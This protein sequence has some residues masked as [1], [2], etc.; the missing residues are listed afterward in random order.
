MG[1]NVKIKPHTNMVL[2]A[3]VY[4]CKTQS[5]TRKKVNGLMVSDAFADSYTDGT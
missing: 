5:V 2:P 1:E 4:A 3:V